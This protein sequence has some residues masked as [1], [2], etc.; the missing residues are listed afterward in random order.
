[1]TLNCENIYMARTQHYIALSPYTPI[2]LG[3]D[4]RGSIRRPWNVTPAL[5][6]VS[7]ITSRFSNIDQ[8]YDVIANPTKMHEVEEQEE[9]ALR[10][11]VVQ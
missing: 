4:C 1:M 3:K 9:E 5:R 2:P 11:L 7:T 8:V 10:L 6:R